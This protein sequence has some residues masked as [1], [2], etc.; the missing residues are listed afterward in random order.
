MN[1][2]LIVIFVLIL[3]GCQT[4]IYEHTRKAYINGK[5]AIEGRCVFTQNQVRNIQIACKTGPDEY[6]KFY[7]ILSTTD[8]IFVEVVPENNSNPYFF[9][10]YISN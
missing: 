6:R 8:T 1:K 7:L 5:L 2:F 3:A 4:N 10:H 9:K